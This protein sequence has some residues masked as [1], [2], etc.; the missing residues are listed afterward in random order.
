MIRDAR[1]NA[2]HSSQEKATKEDFRTAVI[3]QVEKE[4]NVNVG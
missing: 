3:V 4:L 1:T 2:S